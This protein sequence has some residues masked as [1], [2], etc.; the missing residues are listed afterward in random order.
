MAV[1]VAVSL[2]LVFFVVCLFVLVTQDSVEAGA[3]SVHDR[4]GP[5]LPGYDECVRPKPPPEDLER[6][7]EIWVD[8]ADSDNVAVTGPARIGAREVST[9]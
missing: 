3:S 1:A 7:S 9:R 4:D 6:M 2:A 8:C 5:H